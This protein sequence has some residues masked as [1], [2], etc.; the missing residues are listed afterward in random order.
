MEIERNYYRRL[1]LQNE[2]KISAISS[3]LNIPI[4]Y[5]SQWENNKRDLS[6]ED[7]ISLFKLFNIDYETFIDAYNRKIDIYNKLLLELCYMRQSM[8]NLNSQL[9]VPKSNS[10]EYPYYLVLKLL[11]NC[12]SNNKTLV[13]GDHVHEYT[14]YSNIN[15]FEIQKVSITTQH[16][17]I[18]KSLDFNVY[19]CKLVDNAKDPSYFAILNKKV[20]KL[21]GLSDLC[22]YLGVNKSD[23]I[24]FGDDYNDLDILTHSGHAVVVNNASE[25]LKSYADDICPSNDEDGVAKWIESSLL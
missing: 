18:I 11:F 23:V 5:I 22:D 4:A 2:Y 15:T 16:P 19:N 9:D 12:S 10:L 13:T 3:M 24:A 20:S 1:R 21:A 25:D 14:D 8:E 6:N 17:E 7:V